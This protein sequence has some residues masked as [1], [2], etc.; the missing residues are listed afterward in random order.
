MG[1]KYD[2]I[3][4]WYIFL[5]IFTTFWHLGLKLCIYELTTFL[6]YGFDF[7]S[8]LGTFITKVKIKQT[9]MSFVDAVINFTRLQRI[10]FLGTSLKEHENLVE[11][12]CTTI[13]I[14]LTKYAFYNY[15]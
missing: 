11:K 6:T 5:E 7:N 12:Q 13:Q 10:S 14:H 8:D 3:S 15:T 4:F 1:L 9:Y 2:E